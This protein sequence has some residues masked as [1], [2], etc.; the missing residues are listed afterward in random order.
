[1]STS[2]APARHTVTPLA[3][4]DL[5]T[6]LGVFDECL[7]AGFVTGP[8][9]LDY[10]ESPVKA[11]VGVQG[12][13]AIATG[14]LYSSARELISSQPDDQA[15]ALDALLDLPP[16]PAGILK[17]VAVHQ[18]S[19]RKG[20]AGELVRAIASQLTGMGAGSIVSLGWTDADGCHI[21]TALESAGFTAAGDIT[22]YW[23]KDSLAHGYSCPSCGLPCLCTA[24]IFR[25]APQQP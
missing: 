14:A 19:R 11:A 10:M 2:S 6:A 8:E 25:Y 7:G 1:M 20:M 3:G 23:R 12:G 24:R 15:A 5:E 4:G 9:L 16:G 21:Q 17:S 18:D 22:D 13:K